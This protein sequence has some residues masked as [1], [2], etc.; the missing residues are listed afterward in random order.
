MRVELGWMG[1]PGLQ[2]HRGGR[3][4][5][6]RFTV[7]TIEGMTAGDVVTIEPRQVLRVTPTA[8]TRD[9]VTLTFSQ[10]VDYRSLQTVWNRDCGHGTTGV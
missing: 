6:T 1:L 3:D 5:S 7:D 9:A 2:G 8:G 4:W 10:I